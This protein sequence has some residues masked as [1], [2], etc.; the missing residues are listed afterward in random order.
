MLDALAIAI[1]DV[2]SVDIAGLSDGELEDAVVGLQAQRD[3][4]EAAHARVAHAWNQQRVW[5]ESGAKSGQAWLARATRAPKPACGS[6]LWLGKRAQLMPAATLAW[7]AG[8]IGGDH[9]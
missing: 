2:G 3:A 8:E 5:A 9:I 1:K 4:L 7:E 6:L